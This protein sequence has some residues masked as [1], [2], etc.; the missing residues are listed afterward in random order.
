MLAISVS[1]VGFLGAVLFLFIGL[2]L[3]LSC[4]L[5]AAM[6]SSALFRTARSSKTLWILL[7]F[8][9]GPLAAGIYFAFVRPRIRIVARNQ[10]S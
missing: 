3:P 4:I 6:T 2:I 5:D 7:P 1:G 9:F 10:K 8:F